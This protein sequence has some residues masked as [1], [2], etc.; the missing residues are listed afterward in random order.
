[1]DKTL[2]DYTL[3]EKN[4]EIPM[5]IFSPTIINDGRRLVIGT[6]PMS[7]LN[8]TD[9]GG[10]IVGPENVEFIKIFEKN[11][12]FKVKFTSVLRMNSTFPYILPAVSLPTLPELTQWM[13][14]FAII[15]AQ[16]RPF[17]YILALEDW[18]AENTSG[19]IMLEIRDINK[20][21]D[22]SDKSDYSLFDRVVKP[23]SNFYGNYLHA[24]E[25]NADELL[26]AVKRGK[27]TVDVITFVLRENPNERISLSWHLTQ[28]EKK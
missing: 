28:R 15:M 13:Q 27:S 16:K 17:V 26:E 23:V 14:E 3:A 9:L 4:S 1:M 20:D 12:P 6:Q 22:V 10:K 11:N 21:Y 2:G 25:Y 8:G 18:I 24:Q 7:F 5:M 19:I